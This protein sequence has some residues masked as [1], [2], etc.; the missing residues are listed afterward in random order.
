MLDDNNKL[1]LDNNCDYNT[2]N[3]IKRK[4]YNA[5]NKIYQS[6]EELIINESNNRTKIVNIKDDQKQ[7][8]KL[9]LEIE[10][11]LK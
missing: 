9:L 8:K 6:L 2:N 5:L 1:I 10:N 11:E 4:K 7:I 3:F